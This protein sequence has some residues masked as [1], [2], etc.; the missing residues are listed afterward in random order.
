[1]KI[2]KKKK[3]KKKTVDTEVMQQSNVKIM[4]LFSKE[5]VALHR[6]GSRNKCLVLKSTSAFEQSLHG[7][8]FTFI[9]VI[10]SVTVHVC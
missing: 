6:W 8:Q 7:G 10:N 4:V 3:Q 9:L 2:K 1:M 5:T